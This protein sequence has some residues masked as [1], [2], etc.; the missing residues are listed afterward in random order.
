MR[1]PHPARVALSL[2]HQEQAVPK[3]KHFAA[4]LISHGFAAQTDH[5]TAAD[6]QHKAHVLVL[7]LRQ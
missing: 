6:P 7:A 3:G 1:T 5:S 4:E 2:Q